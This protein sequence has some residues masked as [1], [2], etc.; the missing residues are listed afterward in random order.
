VSR[1]M[2]EILSDLS[3]QTRVQSVISRGDYLMTEMRVIVTY[4]RLIFLPVNQNLDYDYPVS[5]SFFAPSVFL[6][7][8]FLLSILGTALSLL[9]RT[10]QEAIGNGQLEENIRQEAR[11][12]G[13]GEENKEQEVVSPIANRLPPIACYRLIAFGILWFFITLSVESSL[14]PIA[15]VI[16]EHRVYLPSAGAFIALAATLCAA[17][18]KAEDM[19]APGARVFIPLALIIVALSGVT[20]ARNT[21]WKDSLTLWEDVVGKSPA[22]ARAHNNLGF[23][24]H[25]RGMT[26]QAIEQCVMA[27]RL[28]PGYTDARI[29]LGIAYNA[30]GMIDQAIEQFMIA[31]SMS[32]DDADAHNN[33]GISYVSKGMID[34]GIRHYQIALGI[35]SD[36]PEAY[37]NLG[38]AYGSRGMY[39]QAIGYF[40]HALL[41][42]PGYFEARHNLAL[43]YQRTGRHDE[44]A[45]V[46]QQVRP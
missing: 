40:S 45:A 25:A 35:R 43:A 38:V 15:D 24:Y 36:Y 1:P 41:L 42:K 46:Y 12:D 22:N 2:G 30:K 11:G 8:L 21:V 37:N 5:H 10:R 23:I 26:D 14:I 9:Y 16:F 39:D 29:N 7:F 6:S 18:T 32:P 20:F 3:E 44:A 4:I 33:L 27:V 31:L 28:R 19:W 13:Q 17:A 34:Q